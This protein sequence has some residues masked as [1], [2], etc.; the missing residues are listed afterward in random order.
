MK[1]S[2][3]YDGLT[4]PPSPDWP[5]ERQRE[6]L[7]ALARTGD[8]AAAAEQVGATESALRNLRKARGKSSNF[9]RAW[10]RINSEARL[11]ALAT[12]ILRKHGLGAEQLARLDASC[13]GR[14]KAC[15]ALELLRHIAALPT[16][17]TE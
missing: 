13:R 14:D 17:S 6:F 5:G 16:G 4:L 15:I 12:N 1:H 8:V 3:T 2:A 11:G 9:S 10:G 7:I